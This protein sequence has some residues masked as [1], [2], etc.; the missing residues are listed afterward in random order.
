MFKGSRHSWFD[1]EIESSVVHYLVP[2]IYLLSVPVVINRKPIYKP[3][4][5]LYGIARLL[6]F[7]GGSSGKLGSAGHAVFP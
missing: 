7:A 2:H 4:T 1:E 6:L 5:L 3:R